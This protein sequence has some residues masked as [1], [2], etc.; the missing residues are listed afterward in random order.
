MP[1]STSVRWWP[2]TSR[3]PAVV[4]S[5]TNAWGGSTDRTRQIAGR[6]RGC[7]TRA[8]LPAR[9]GP[10]SSRSTDVI[11][12]VTSGQPATSSVRDHTRSGGAR[13]SVSWVRRTRPT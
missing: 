1:P 2:A 13:M 7:T 11:V 5:Q 9:S 10:S 12:G 8:R 6:W 4:A 3:T